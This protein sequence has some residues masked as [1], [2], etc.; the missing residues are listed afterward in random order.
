MRYP[1]DTQYPITQEFG[2]NPGD[3]A[4]FNMR[5]HNGI[6]FGPPTGTNVYAAAPG[7]VER[8]TFD[9]Q[10]YGF[11]I[12]IKHADGLTSVYAHLS[13]I[14]VQPG[15]M[16]KEGQ[17]LGQTGSTGNSTGPHLHFE[18]RRQG[19]EGN[20]Y[21]GA[22]DPRPLIDW[23]GQVVEPV[24]PTPT[25]VIR[26]GVVAVDVLNVRAGP[27]LGY[28]IMAM[29]KRGDTV[30]PVELREME[31]WGMLEPG[32]WVA[33]SWAGSEMVHEV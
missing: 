9:D 27:G 31:V 11:Y 33:L 26:T 21:H 23:P 2:D 20:G 29:L 32:R 12:Q 8:A 28:P 5:A 17:L 14:R 16:V 24:E 7:T 6:D 1:F 10:G 19:L 30:A 25:V 22:I 4:R 15:V 13:Q 18:V 3:Y